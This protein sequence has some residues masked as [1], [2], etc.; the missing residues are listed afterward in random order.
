MRSSSCPPGTWMGGCSMSVAEETW[1]GSSPS[2]ASSIPSATLSP[3]ALPS[4]TGSRP[5]AILPTIEAN[6]DT[7]MEGMAPPVLP[8][9]WL[10][11]PSVSSGDWRTASSSFGRTKARVQSTS[12]ANLWRWYWTRLTACLSW[13]V[14]GGASLAGGGGTAQQRASVILPSTVPADA[15]DGR[16]LDSGAAPNFAD[17]SLDSRVVPPDDAAALSA[18]PY[19]RRTASFMASKAGYTEVGSARSTVNM[20]VAVED[21]AGIT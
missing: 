13:K 15:G 7:V 16:P 9:G 12:D 10:E 8:P 21:A 17:R 1:D 5:C 2:L 20:S 19:R 14:W 3:L 4:S 6:F 11:A 18:A